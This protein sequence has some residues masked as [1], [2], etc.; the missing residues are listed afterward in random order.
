MHDA[1]V[2]GAERRRPNAASLSHAAPVPRRSMRGREM[3]DDERHAQKNLRRTRVAV[4]GS[5]AVSTAVNIVLIGFLARIGG[6]DLVGTWALFGA[7]ILNV[8]I[9][10]LGVTNALTYR[11]A[12]QGLAG[13]LPVLRWLVRLAVIPVF[14]F[15]VAAVFFW[16][17]DLDGLL[18]GTLAALAGALQLLS[19]WLIAIRMGQHQQYWFNIKTILRVVVQGAAVVV[20]MSIS[21]DSIALGAALLAG[22]VAEFALSGLLVARQF[23]LQGRVASRSDVRRALDGFGLLGLADRG[24]QPLVQFA[25]AGVEGATALG[26]FTVALRIPVVINQTVAEALR[27]LLPGVAAL[28]AKGNTGAVDRLLRDALVTQI[29]LVVPALTA[30]VFSADWVAEVWLGQVEP[31]LVLA[32]RLFALNMVVVSVATPYFWAVQAAG[33]ARAVGV[34]SVLR[35]LIVLA[36]GVIASLFGAGVMGFVLAFSL[37]QSVFSLAVSLVAHFRYDLVRPSLVDLC[38]V[39]LLMYVLLS[40]VLNAGLVNLLQDQKSELA[41]IAAFC[42]NAIIFGPL[43]IVSLARGAM[44]STGSPKA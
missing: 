13:T 41:L 20:L 12:H 42:A 18:G 24:Y 11:I 44:V 17:F 30:L 37:G 34:L 36:A 27:T 26:V 29:V 35:L 1:R 5:F 19:G 32:M 38:K 3:S 39:R 21:R 43:V 25:V 28:R 31:P 23:P 4:G 22:A 6:L 9:L 2:P 40:L 10:D 33:G 15:A 16:R 14:G 8:L 7:I